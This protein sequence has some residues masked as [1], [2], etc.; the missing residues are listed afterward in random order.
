M[1]N[2]ERLC[3]FPCVL[4]FLYMAVPLLCN[5]YFGDFASHVVYI[6]LA[7]DEASRLDRLRLGST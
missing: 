5:L 4:A 2:L 7:R 3:E 1:E 6:K